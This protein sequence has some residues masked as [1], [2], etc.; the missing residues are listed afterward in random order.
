MISRAPKWKH[1]SQGPKASGQ[2]EIAK[3]KIKKFK[4]VN[5]EKTVRSLKVSIRERMKHV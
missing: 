2:L 1:R 4:K 3:K 5:E